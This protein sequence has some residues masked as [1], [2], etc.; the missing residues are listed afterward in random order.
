MTYLAETFE[1]TA[2]GTA[3]TAANSGMDGFALTAGDTMAFDNGQA[4]H[5]SQSMKVIKAGAT[6]TGASYISWSTSMGT[7]T[8]AWFRIYAWV[9]AAPA[10][11]N[12][13][14]V[15]QLQGTTSC[16]RAGISNAGKLICQDA[17]GLNPVNGTVPCNTSAWFRIEGYFIGSATAGQIQ[18]KLWNTMDSTGAPTDTITSSAAYNTFGTMD[19]FRYGSCS[20]TAVGLNYTYWVDDIAL[21]NVAYIGAAGYITDPETCSGADGGPGPSGGTHEEVGVDD[22]VGYP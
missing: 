9:S 14:L 17:G 11:T 2:S 12:L 22:A 1:E 5:G 19:H 10:T 3:V 21:S 15:Q 20:S 16:G 13:W 8:Q 6:G 7:Q 4:A 18:L